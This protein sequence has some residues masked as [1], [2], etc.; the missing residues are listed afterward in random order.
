[1]NTCIATRTIPQ[2]CYHGDHCAYYGDGD[3][4]CDGGCACTSGNTHAG[5]K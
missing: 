2:T 4:G 1:M 5:K 3:D